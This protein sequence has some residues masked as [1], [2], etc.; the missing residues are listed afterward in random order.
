M[1]GWFRPLLI[2][3]GRGG[4]GEA[5]GEGGRGAEERQAWSDGWRMALSLSGLM[6]GLT[7]GASASVRGGS[8]A[9]GTSR[10]GLP[11]GQAWTASARPGQRQ[12]VKMMA[13]KETYQALVVVNDGEP[14]ESALR[15]FKREVSKSNVIMELRRRRNFENSQDK[16]KRKNKEAARRR[17]MARKASRRRFEAQG[18]L[19]DATKFN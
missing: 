1:V 10:V 7:L 16:K 9:T 2:R 11:L 17:T 15:R 5:G 18:A 14:A 12:T 13:A 3:R 19:P 4:K 6:G 8:F